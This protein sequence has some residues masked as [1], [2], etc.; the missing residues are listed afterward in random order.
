LENNNK[1]QTAVSAR[2]LVFTGML[3]CVKLYQNKQVESASTTSLLMNFRRNRKVLPAKL[4]VGSISR[5]G[6]TK[7]EKPHFSATFY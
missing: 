7:G 3:I 2:R 5:N 6:R 1:Y 4:Y